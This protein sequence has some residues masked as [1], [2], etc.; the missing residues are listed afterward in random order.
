MG[1]DAGSDDGDVFAGSCRRAVL[2]REGSFECHVLHAAGIEGKT[3][4][5]AAATKIVV[6]S[7]FDNHPDAMLSYKGNGGR[8]VLSGCSVDLQRG[9]SPQGTSLASRSEDAGIAVCRAAG[10]PVC[11]F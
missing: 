9:E 6:A 8:D 5:R 2:S 7:V 3:V 10:F 1:I 11:G 4:G